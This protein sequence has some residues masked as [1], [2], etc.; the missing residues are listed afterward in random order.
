MTIQKSKPARKINKYMIY[1]FIKKL[2]NDTILSSDYVNAM[3]NSFWNIYL[4]I[5]HLPSKKSNKQK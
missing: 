3:F 4:R 1:D 5:F 2:S